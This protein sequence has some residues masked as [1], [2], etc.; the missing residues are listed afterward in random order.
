MDETIC[1][2][3]VQNSQPN[4][5]SYKT[6]KPNSDTTSPTTP[7]PMPEDINELRDHI[8][9]VIRNGDERSRKALLQAL[10]LGNKD[11]RHCG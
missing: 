5:L 11:S 2:R 10:T 9:D 4:S 3:R 1:G 6:A 8:A 7:P